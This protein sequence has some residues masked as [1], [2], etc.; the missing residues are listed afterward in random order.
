LLSGRQTVTALILRPQ[1]AWG[2][3]RT[4][5][6]GEGRDKYREVAGGPSRNPLRAWQEFW[7]V[8]YMRSGATG[9]SNVWRILFRKANLETGNSFGK[10]P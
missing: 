5:R 4:A 10:L 9:G 7:A 6:E 8:L 2:I 3:W 1:S